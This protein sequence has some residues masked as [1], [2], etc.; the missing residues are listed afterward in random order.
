[1]KAERVRA[2]LTA[3]DASERTLKSLRAASTEGVSFLM[4]PMDRASLGRRVGKGE[5]AAIGVL[6]SR[7]TRLLLRQLHR[8]LN[9]G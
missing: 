5:R 8:L 3:S 4:L 6:A 1:L 2:V 7:S 9:L